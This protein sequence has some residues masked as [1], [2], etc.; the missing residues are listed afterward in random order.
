MS[1]I[2]EKEKGTKVVTKEGLGIGSI[3]KSKMTGDGGVVLSTFSWKFC[4]LFVLWIQPEVSLH[5]KK[6]DPQ[7][8]AN[9]WYLSFF[10]FV[11]VCEREK[12]IFLMFPFCLGEAGINL[13]REKI[14]YCIPIPPPPQIITAAQKKG[15]G[16]RLLWHLAYDNGGQAVVRLPA[17]LA[18]GRENTHLPDRCTWQKG[19]LYLKCSPELL[20]WW[21]V[22]VA[23]VY[24]SF[25][26]HRRVSST[27][28]MLV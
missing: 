16:F 26:L 22:G 17:E 23:W 8:N 4:C 18:V 28:T 15:S 11:C 1:C 19:T 14:W 3:G 7:P 12:G 20:C 2:Q 21:S 9:K 5:V 27:R 25:V 10:P 6:K 13:Q 24:F